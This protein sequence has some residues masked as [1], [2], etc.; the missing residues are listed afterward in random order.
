[1]QKLNM[2]VI[3]ARLGKAAGLVTGSV[4][5]GYVNTALD[6]M[7]K[8]KITPTMNAG[9]RIGIAAALPSFLG[10]KGKGGF[11]T[12]FADGMMASAGL[13]LAKAMGVPG[14]TG[15]D[16][17]YPVGYVPEDYMNGTPSD[18]PVSGTQD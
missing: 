3:Q 18:T 5:S 6:K 10:E 12:D 15:T 13:S 9:I 2:K 14:I 11:M 7:G 8:G 1:M 4:A 17:A 16:T